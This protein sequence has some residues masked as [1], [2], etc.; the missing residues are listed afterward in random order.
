M[1]KQV[2]FLNEKLERCEADNPDAM[3]AAGLGRPYPVIRLY[4]PDLEG[5]ERKYVLEC[6]NS[7]W[8]SSNGLFVNRF[9]EE[10][11]RVVGSKHAIAVTNGT[12]ALHLALHALGIGPGDEVIVPSL[13]YIA[14]VNA[15]AQTG[16]TPV[17]ADSCA[18]DWLLD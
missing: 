3:D 2:N 18:E 11:A 13:T 8:I 12:V 17:F 1:G 15:I 14:S 16:A 9:E 6:L 10:F 4:Q 7:S 5:N